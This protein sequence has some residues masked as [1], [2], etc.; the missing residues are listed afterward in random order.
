MEAELLADLEVPGNP[1]R[2]FFA[3]HPPSDSRSRGRTKVH[4]WGAIGFASPP[5][6]ERSPEGVSSAVGHRKRDSE[7]SR[8][9]ELPT[10]KKIFAT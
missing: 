9:K 3:M 1:R 8:S 7:R 4:R 6:R 2:D 10:E 5:M